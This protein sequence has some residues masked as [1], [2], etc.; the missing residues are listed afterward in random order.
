[1]RKHCDSLGACGRGILVGGMAGLRP[2]WR[3][4]VG[5][6]F[7]CPTPILTLLRYITIYRSILRGCIEKPSAAQLHSFKA[8]RMASGT[9][10]TKY[11]RHLF[12]P[13]LSFHSVR[14]Q[15]RYARSG[16]HR[17]QNSAET[18]RNS[19]S[20]AEAVWSKRTNV[21]LSMDQ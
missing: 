16:W 12:F 2:D 14:N 3:I 11:L 6:D 4:S 21:G 17:L 7:Q 15:F 18:P 19:S 13:P 1:V 8:G 5:C 9:L 10:Y 20:E